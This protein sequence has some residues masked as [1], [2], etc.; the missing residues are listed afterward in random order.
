MRK[1]Q[2]TLILIIFAFL[3]VASLTLF[4][5]TTTATSIEPVFNEPLRIGDKIRTNNY[6]LELDA[7]LANGDPDG[8]SDGDGDGSTYSIV[9]VKYWLSLDDYFGYYF[10]SIFELWDV[11]IGVF[12][13]IWIQQ[14]RSWPDPDP[15]GRSDPDITADQVTILL[16]EFESNIVPTDEAYFGTPDYH[17]GSNAVFDDMVGLPADY[18]ESDTGKTVILVSNIRDDNFHTIYPYYIAGFY[19]PSFEFYFDRNIIS[20]DSYQWEE[21]VGP[22]GSRPYLYEGVIAHEYQHLIND[23]Y[24]PA[25]PSFMNEG[26]SML[27]E[28]LCGYGIA[29]GDINSYLATPDNSLTEWGDQGGINILADYGQSLL[30]VLY[31]NDHFEDNFISNFVQDGIPGIAGINAA[32]T[33]FGKTFDEVYH[34]WRIANVIHTDT[35]GDGKYNYDTIDLGG[36]NADPIRVYEVKEKWPTAMTG[37][38]FGTTTTI[39]GYDTGISSVSTYGSD[40][41]L[42]SKLKWQ[43]NSWLEFDGNDQITAPTWIKEDMDGDGDLEWYSTTAGSLAD[44]LLLAQIDLTGYADSIMLSFDTFYIIEDLWDYGFVQVSIDGG[45]TWASLSN[46]YT[47]IAHDPAAHPDIT[48]NLP[49]LTDSS[50]GWINMEFD[51]TPY[52]GLNVLIGF[53]Y[54]TDWAF[55][56]D[57][58]WI[59]NVYVGGDLIDD[60]DDVVAFYFPDNPETD[61]IVT[62]IRVDYWKN[63]PFYSLINDMDIDSETETGSESLFLYTLKIHKRSKL[64]MIVSPKLGPTD[65]EFSVI[66]GI[67]WK[68]G[69]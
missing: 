34:D 64:L 67:K 45:S 43:Y 32:L 66:K 33:P 10:L 13:E 39:L 7:D 51:L 23:D 49:G 3:N 47:T 58:W 29:W 25:N 61:F 62:L 69:W 59:D 11:G 37:N 38:G 57:G 30:W 42:F 65:Y 26:A 53:R 31:L 21:R 56:L 55:E 20:I 5:S 50:D 52:A 2:I 46:T 16:D 6:G 17:N 63:E 1:K 12:S 35:P 40:Y 8:D 41:I 22:D 14:D 48:D 44:L 28:Y 15:Q 54:M 27:A 9:D 36:P 24:N 68:R 18:Y 4:V 19:S 60:A